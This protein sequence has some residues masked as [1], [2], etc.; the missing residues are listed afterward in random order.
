[1]STE[2]MRRDSAIVLAGGQSRRLGRDKRRLRLWGEGGP[3]LLERTVATVGALCPDVVVV[4]NDPEGWLGLPGRI[5]PDQY[6]DGGALGGIYSGLTAAAGEYAL[7]VAC[8]MPLLSQPL[9]AAMLAR[10][11][12]YDVLAPRSLSPGA[13]RNSLDLE[14][15][16][17]IYGKGCL[18]PM[19]E[20]LERGRRQIASFFPQVR[21]AVF[22]PEETRAHDPEGHSFLNINTVEQMERALAALRGGA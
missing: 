8:D 9:L 11:R 21:V 19:R 13:T 15:L 7:V 10:P 12:D 16:H 4:L 6:P 20:A 5:V 2:T 14:T 17:A 1:M 18:G 3:T 22:E